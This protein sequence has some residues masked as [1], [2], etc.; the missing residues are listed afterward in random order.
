M[1]TGIE[2]RNP[3]GPNLRP[4]VL[5][6][7]WSEYFDYETRAATLHAITERELLAELES[8]RRLPSPYLDSQQ[9]I[10]RVLT[11]L[12]GQATFH[13]QFNESFPNYRP[14]QILGMQ[15]Y[16]IMARDTTL[17]VYTQTQH[18]GHA[19][20]HSVYFIPKGDARYNQLVASSAV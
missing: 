1:L 9:A 11:R 5:E 12:G 17:W 13:R 4:T 16:S 2:F 6:P 10:S 15:L 8:A 19:F 7:Y 18:A 14:H 20:P 3:I